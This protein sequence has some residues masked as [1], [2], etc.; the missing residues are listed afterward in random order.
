MWDLIQHFQ[1]DK[2]RN[3][4]REAIRQA[5]G[6]RSRVASTDEKVERLTLA[7]QAMWEL[8]RD[9]HGLTEDQLYAKI[10]EID[11]RDGKF[12]GKVGE[13]IIQCPHCGQ[14]TSTGKLR[15]V[16]CGKGV[17]ASHSFKS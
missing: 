5:D 7:C 3:E 11:A 2:A 13:E 6:Q 9:H 17:K 10:M 16:Y 4:A 1:I 12:D 15:C 8:L 14:R